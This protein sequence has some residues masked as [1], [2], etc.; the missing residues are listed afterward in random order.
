MGELNYKQKVMS[1]Y[2]AAE[3]IHDGMT[4]AFEGRLRAVILSFCRRRFLNYIR[5]MVLK[6]MF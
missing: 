4:I 2:E 3:L 1:A 6:S 5:M